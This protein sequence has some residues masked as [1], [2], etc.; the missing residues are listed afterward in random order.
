MTVSLFA[1]DFFLHIFDSYFKLLSTAQQSTDID[2]V[3]FLQDQWL[4][5]DGSWFYNN[6]WSSESPDS[7]D[8]CLLLNSNGKKTHT[9]WS[10]DPNN[11][12]YKWVSQAMGV[13]CPMA[14]SQ[15]KGENNSD[16][17][18]D[19]VSHMD[20]IFRMK[21]QSHFCEFGHLSSEKLYNTVPRYCHGLCLIFS[22]HRGMEQFPMQH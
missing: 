9:W 22:F 7:T 8:P 1:I 14:C 3:L 19:F 17:E 15:Y 21:N 12:L 20:F 18:N 5:I 2:I 13:N 6:N 10:R 16:C 4:W 11:T